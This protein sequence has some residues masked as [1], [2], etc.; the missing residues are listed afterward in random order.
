MWIHDIYFQN[1]CRSQVIRVFFVCLFFFLFFVFDMCMFWVLFSTVDI[2]KCL[3]NSG[4]A[5][6][7]VKFWH[8]IFFFQIIIDSLRL[9]TIWV[10]LSSVQ[11]SLSRVWLFATHGLHH[12]RLPCP[13]PPTP[14][15]YSNPCPSGLWCHPPISSCLPLLLLP[16]VF[17]SIRLFSKDSVLRIR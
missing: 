5:I 4:H 12:A 9:K 10:S 11:S 15:V 3:M 2:Q 8:C 7:S 13:S 17:P 6:S 16:S 1:K 14:G